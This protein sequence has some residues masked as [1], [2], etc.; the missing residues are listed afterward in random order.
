MRDTAIL[1]A[2]NLTAMILAPILL[3]TVACVGCSGDTSTEEAIE[4]RPGGPQIRV[5]VARR[6]SVWLGSLGDVAV[7]T[8]DEG[9]ALLEAEIPGRIAVE[10]IDGAIDVGGRVRGGALA[11]SR[12]EAQAPFEVAWRETGDDG[13]L[14]RGS[15][16]LRVRRGEVEIVNVLSL[17]EYLLGV[18]GSEMPALYPTAALEAQAIASRSYALFALRE[19]SG[20]DTVF[21]ADHRFQVYGGVGDEHDRVR[22]AVA[23]TR[24]QV[25]AFEGRLFRTYFHSTCGGHTA[26]ASREFGEPAIPPLAGVE[27]G[28]CEGSKYYRWTSTLPVDLLEA[29]LIR[30]RSS[31]ASKIGRTTGL[32]IAEGGEDGRAVYVRV[33]HTKGA[34]D[35]RASRFRLAIEALRPGTIRSTALRI[36]PLDDGMWRIHGAGWGHGAGMC[37]VGARGLANEGLDASE[38]LERYYPRSEREQ[39][40]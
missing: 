20:G 9:E 35:W 13:R 21:A 26:P 5:L 25:L 30:R 6:R 33:E 12:G 18:L 38:I 4:W 40:Y 34:L 2:T 3:A 31:A 27:C 28:G 15:L 39:A 23:A 37:Q 24:G 32:S 14:Y 7:R 29:A 8:L 16:E 10:V 22:R 36:E 11:I 19:K 17:E 1:A